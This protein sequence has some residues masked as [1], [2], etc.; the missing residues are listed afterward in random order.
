MLENVLQLGESVFGYRRTDIKLI[1]QTSCKVV[2]EDEYQDAQPAAAPPASQNPRPCDLWI[3]RARS[4]LLTLHISFA[5]DLDL[6]S[7]SL[8]DLST[9]IADHIENAEVSPSG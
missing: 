2:Y 3:P 1:T 8:P 7:V 4:F 5:D 6:T 9:T